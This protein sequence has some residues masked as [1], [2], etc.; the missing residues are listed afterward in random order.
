[1]MNIDLSTLKAHAQGR[2]RHIHATLGIPVELLNPHKHQP[3]PHCGGKDRFRYT[4]YQGYGGFICNQCTP[5]GGSGLDLIMLVFGYTFAEAV[6]AV[7]G[8]LGMDKPVD[9]PAPIKLPVSV[10]KP[11]QDKQAVLASLLAQTAF[12]DDSS[13][14]KCYLQQRGLDWQRIASHTST[15]RFHAALP[16]WTPN[17][18]SKPLHLGN[19]P[20][21]IAPITT[22]A[23]ELMGIHCTYL[24]QS[25][26]GWSKLV[27]AHPQT[28]EPLPA[29]KM[30]SRYPQAL[31]GAAVY[32]AMPDA[33]GRL[34]VAEGIETALAAQELFGLPVIAA[35]SAHGMKSLVLPDSVTELFIVADNDT[36]NIGMNVAHTLAIRAIKTGIKAHI[37]QSPTQGFDALDE[38][39]K[40]KGASK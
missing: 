34:I 31:T 25:K 40:R 5:Q 28:G 20:A 29:K 2:W 4:D 16:Y 12:I 22:P 14:V 1:M 9:T 23:G 27:L 19:F 13:P 21:M 8:V 10:S 15:L 7:A 37:W 33:Q 3:C 36:S 17:T 24:M 39:N 30:Q 35:L 38:L 11:I 26:N 6:Q 32:L 18:Q